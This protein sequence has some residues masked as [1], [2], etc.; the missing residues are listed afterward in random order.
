VQGFSTLVTPLRN[1]TRHN[2][3]WK[4]SDRCQKAF[5]L[6]KEALT[7]APVLASPDFDKPFEVVSDASGFGVGAVLLQEGRPVA[8]ESKTLS[9]AEQNYHTTDREMLGVIH[10]LRTW[11]CYLEG[12][13]FT[14]VTDHCPNTFFATKSNLSR[15]QARWSEF[16]QRFTFDWCYRPG[17]TNVAD[18]LGR[19][20][21]ETVC[22]TLRTARMSVGKEGA[23]CGPVRTFRLGHHPGS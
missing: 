2:V 21:V 10:A 7:K 17:R 20:P 4:W 16:L 1:L 18:P 6:V 22:F 11:R 23:H 15:R 19:F 9:A 14:V 13:Q 12:V 3:D 5:Q 8:F